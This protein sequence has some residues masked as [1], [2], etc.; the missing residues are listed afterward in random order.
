MRPQVALRSRPTSSGESSDTCQV[1][2]TPFFMG[3]GQGVCGDHP[4]LAPPPPPAS[5][6]LCTSQSK[7]PYECKGLL[8]T[9]T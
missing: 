1:L 7:L 6:L 3:E 8:L 5:T 9:I 4:P 2:G